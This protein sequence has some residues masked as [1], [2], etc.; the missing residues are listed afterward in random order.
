MVSYAGQSFVAS[1]DLSASQYMFVRMSAAA[2]FEVSAITNANAQ[3]PFGILQNDPAAAGEAAEVAL[4]GMI[5]KAV[6]GGT[7][8]E[9][10][11]LGCNNTGDVIA[12][13]YET[14]PA[15]ADLYINALALEAGVDGDIIKV[16]V[17]TPVKAS[18]E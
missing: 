1:G 16:L 11:L 7:V 2:S 8:D 18:T 10:D 12:A 13:P 4:P 17:L 3:T 14:S 9:G 15:T 6:C 5:A